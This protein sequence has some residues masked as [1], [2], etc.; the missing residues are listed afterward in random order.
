MS[1]AAL[2]GNASEPQHR[3]RWQLRLPRTLSAFTVGGSVG[4]ERRVGAKC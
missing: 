2:I 1:F 3:H 4:V